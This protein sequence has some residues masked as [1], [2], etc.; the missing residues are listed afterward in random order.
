MS[1]LAFSS[2]RVGESYRI[3]NFGEVFE[4]KLVKMLS[5]QNCL[6]QDIHSLEKLTLDDLVQF[7]KGNDWS[8]T[9]YQ[10]V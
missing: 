3:T 4:V 5:N 2:L 9:E 6:L 1:G 7:G 10:E 8:I